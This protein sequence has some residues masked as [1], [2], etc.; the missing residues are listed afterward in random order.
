A[1]MAVEYLCERFKANTNAPTAVLGVGRR[2]LEKDD[3]IAGTVFKNY[4][5]A[6]TEDP[7]RAEILSYFAWKAYKAERFA[8]ANTCFRALEAELRARG[9]TGDSLEKAVYIQAECS[10]NVDAFD[11]F[12]SEFPE[13][14]LAPRALG[15]KAQAQ[16]VAGGFDAAFHSLEE[17]SERYPGAPSARTALAGLIV[18]AIE[19][20]RFDIAGQ[21]LARMLEDKQAYGNNVY[22][23]TGETLLAAD[24]FSLSETAFAAVSPSTERSFHGLAAA[25]FG[26]G[27]F[28][29]S[30]QTL[31]RLLSKYPSSGFFH[32]ARL[33]QA[34]ALVQL[35]RT[36][37]AIA[38]YGEVV[39]GRQDYEVAF[40]MA[41]ILA[42]PEAQLAAYQRIAL[43]A[44]P[45]KEANRPLIASS[46]VASLPL[47]L[48]MRKYQLA[49]DSCDQFAALFPKHD[50][51]PTIGNFRKEAEHALAQ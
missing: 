13:S 35:G 44:N 43:L 21:V 23:S 11:R 48:E 38:A 28:E 18:A 50:Q 16:L 5:S 4:L 39:S 7:H 30:F 8:E 37:D 51:L 26:Q 40:E 3:E 27:R 10:R 6:F 42:D 34:R 17:L 22:I 33:M 45:D 9:E 41:Q 12:L 46:I 20:E 47:C 19:G 15:G 14:A 29:E 36:D 24:E 49:V 32:A 31:E 25:Q 2:Y 1:L